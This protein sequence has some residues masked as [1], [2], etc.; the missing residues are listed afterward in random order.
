MFNSENNLAKQN[1][2]EELLQNHKNTSKLLATDNPPQTL[3]GLPR[4]SVIMEAL[5]TTKRIKEGGLVV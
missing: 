3:C 4:N 2:S 5:S 1:H